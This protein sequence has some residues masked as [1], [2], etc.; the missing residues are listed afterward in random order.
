MDKTISIKEG[1]K[2]TLNFDLTNFQNTLKEV[3]V[4]GTMKE[5][6]RLESPVPVEIYT[7]TYFKKNPTPNVFEALQNVNGS[8][9]T[10]K[11]QCL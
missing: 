4:T 5:V 2:V 7:P 3:V 11:L 10:T 6:S 9:T 1:E 8:K